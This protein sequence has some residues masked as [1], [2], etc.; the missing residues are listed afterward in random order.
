MRT[1]ASQGGKIGTPLSLSGRNCRLKNEGG[2]IKPLRAYL[3]TY[4]I[5]VINLS[6]ATCTKTSRLD[7]HLLTE[8]TGVLQNQLVKALEKISKNTSNSPHFE[9]STIG[10]SSVLVPE[11][12]KQSSPSIAFDGT[13]YFVVWEDYRRSPYSDIY[14]AR[15]STRG[16]VID[17]FGIAISLGN[18]FQ[19]DPFVAFDGTNYFVVWS[20]HRYGCYDIYGARVTKTGIVLDPDGIV[21][22]KHGVMGGS[23]TN[24][25]HPKV[26]FGSENY[27][28]VWEEMGFTSSS[29]PWSVSFLIYGI[30]V[31]PTGVVLDEKKC[32]PMSMAQGDQKSPF[33]AFA[34]KNFLVVWENRLNNSSHIYGARVTPTGAILDPKGIPIC[35]VEGSQKYPSAATD[36]E[37]YLV[38]WHDSRNGCCDIY[39]AR[40]SPAGNVLDQRDIAISTATN[41]QYSPLVAFDG[42]NYL[43]V[44]EDGRHGPSY[45]MSISLDIYCARVSL[46]GDVLDPRG[47]AISTATNWQCHP[48]SAFDGR[49]YFVVWEDKRSAYDIYG[50]RMSPNGVVLDPEGIIL[51]TQ[52]K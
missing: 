19:K 26:A 38:V 1:N 29:P 39:G 5:L 6:M 45:F 36:G 3:L 21:I 46:G 8:G 27:L 48:L 22:A 7:Q 52:M 23:A 13:N 4:F 15:V 34:G 25:E 28:V 42:K 20:D 37:N 17:P 43:V 31:T 33:V 49:N 51:S 30:R 16:K 9:D 10:T 35:M 18:G 14:G 11:R 41:R 2:K 12:S 47:I 40:V 50:A 24:L 44:W 32:I